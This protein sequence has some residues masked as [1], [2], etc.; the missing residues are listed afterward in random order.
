MIICMQNERVFC[1]WTNVPLTA[2]WKADHICQILNFI[3]CHRTRQESCDPWLQVSL[4]LWRCSTVR[5]IWIV[6]W[7]W[8]MLGWTISEILFSSCYELDNLCVLI[9]WF[10][11]ESIEIWWTKNSHYSWI[12]FDYRKRKFKNISERAQ[13]QYKMDNNDLKS[14]PA[15]IRNSIQ[16]LLKL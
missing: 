11:T 7:I 9:G 14:A 2:A 13:I 8:S 15:H 3:Y 5:S 4:H 16:E 1:S 6:L 12:S 10:F